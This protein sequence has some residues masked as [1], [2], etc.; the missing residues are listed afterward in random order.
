MVSQFLSQVFQRKAWDVFI[1]KLCA[2]A[3]IQ[4]RLSGVFLVRSCLKEY[5]EAWAKCSQMGGVGNKNH[6]NGQR[7]GWSGLF[8]RGSGGGVGRERH[9]EGRQTSNYLIRGNPKEGTGSW[10]ILWLGVNTSDNKE[11]EKHDSRV[12]TDASRIPLALE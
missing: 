3:N 2:T 6:A 12:L 10:H 11:R 4:R 7:E 8:K 9:W 5:G 1:S